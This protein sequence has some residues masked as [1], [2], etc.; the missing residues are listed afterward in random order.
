[1]NDR[2]RREGLRRQVED[3]IEKLRGLR[4]RGVDPYPARFERQMTTLEARERFEADGQEGSVVLA[5]RITAIRDHGRSAF[6]DVED[7]SG[8]IQAY[9][10]RDRL[11]EEAYSLLRFLDIGDILGIE[12]PLFRTRTGEITVQVEGLRVLGK[13]LRTPPIVKEEKGEGGER[14][15]VHDAFT[16]KEQRYR[17]RYLDLMVNPEVRR[18]FRTRTRITS[19][20]RAVLEE[21]GYLEVETPVLQ[22]IYGGAFARPFKT[23]HNALGIPLYLR[24]ANELYLK[25]LIIGGFERVFEFAK[26]FRNEGIDRLHNPEF[27]QL[28]L[29][30]A[31]ADYEVMMRLLEAMLHRVAV[32]V[33]G[34]PDIV[35]QGREISFRQPFERISYHEAIEK[36]MGVDVRGMTESELRAIG[37]ERG[38]DLEEKP[39]RGRILEEM[40][41]EFVEPELVA[42][43]FVVDYPREISPLAKRKPDE[44]EVVERFELIVCGGEIANAFSELNDPIDQRARFEEQMSLRAAGDEEAQVIDEDYLKALEYGMPP[45]GGMGIGIDRLV[46]LF[47]DAASIREVILF[48]QMRPE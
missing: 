2:E 7:G 12:G 5:G 37:R 13:A 8:R 25:R 14:G 34:G 46:M 32:E 38:L 3:R 6:L 16:D 17:Q 9:F 15:A 22:P 35:Y 18:I 11:G 19:I 48:P 28:E 31:Y 40:F 20:L 1:M 26:D 4:E 39:G 44:P 29:Y 30:A 43:T 47:T 45:T 41:G 24:I 42:P 27:T 23:F 10:K 36:V 21:E 33:A